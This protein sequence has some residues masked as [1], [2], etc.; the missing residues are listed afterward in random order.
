[1]ISEFFID[2]GF[3]FL[4]GLL[5]KLPDM[6]WEFSTSAFAYLKDFLDMICYLL[7]VG[8]ITNIISMVVAIAF[9]RI[10]IA[11]FRTIWD[12]IPFV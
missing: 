8:T 2:L 4:E 6:T 11:F 1:M 12:L 10:C 9:M 3:S 5:G 7:P